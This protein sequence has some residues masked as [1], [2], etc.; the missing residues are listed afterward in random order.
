MCPAPALGKRAVLSSRPM[1]SKEAL[2]VL[3]PSSSRRTV[4]YLTGPSQ[5]HVTS[6]FHACLREELIDLF[7][8]WLLWVCKRNPWDKLSQTFP[9][10]RHA[11]YENYM[12][13]TLLSFKC[14]SRQHI[15]PVSHPHLCGYLSHPFPTLC[16]YFTVQDRTGHMGGP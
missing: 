16:G 12:C 3:V 2:P 5:G 7:L 10:S 11:L 8:L 13:F 14:L 6:S 15:T 9:A 1:A 4:F